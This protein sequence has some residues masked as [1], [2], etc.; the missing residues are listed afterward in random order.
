M[1][2]PRELPGVISVYRV[3]E[4]G[5]SDRFKVKASSR[6]KRRCQL[7]VRLKAIKY[8]E[9]IFCYLSFYINLLSRLQLVLTL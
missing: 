5:K 9:E 1:Q 3:E 8:K 4:N 7:I 2:G 6:A